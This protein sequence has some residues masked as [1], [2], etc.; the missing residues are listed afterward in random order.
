LPTLLLIGK[1]G[2]R[3]AS[4]SATFQQTTQAKGRFLGRS[5][6]RRVRSHHSLVLTYRQ[7]GM[8]RTRVQQNGISSGAVVLPTDSRLTDARQPTSH[9]HGNITNAGAIGSSPNLPIITAASGVLSAGSFG[10]AAN[11]FC[12]GNDSRLSD[13]RAPVAH[14]HAGL[15]AGS[16]EVLRVTDSGNISTAI[17]GAGATR[18]PGYMCRAWVN[19]RGDAASNLTGTYSVSGTTVTITTS[20]AHGAAVGHI[21]DVDFTSGS[22]TIPIDGNITVTSVTSATVFTATLG[23]SLTTSG[24]ITLFRR[25][26]RASG[27]VSSISYVSIGVL[28]VNMSTPAPHANYAALVTIAH[29]RGVTFSTSCTIDGVTNSSFTV[30][31]AGNTSNLYDPDIVCV[32]VFY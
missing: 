18:Y 20:A 26:I 27:N 5:T 2:Q 12:E 25:A 7:A 31:T 10:T 29:Q 11:T 22:P 24:N 30:N 9:A 16:L 14:V 15:V 21:F 32:A 23:Q 4:I 19:F 6:P 13:A 3:I 28:I 17:E 1:S 8:T